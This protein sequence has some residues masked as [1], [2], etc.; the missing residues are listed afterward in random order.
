[1]SKSEELERIKRVLMTLAMR[2]FERAPSDRSIF[3]KH[4]IDRLRRAYRNTFRAKPKAT[5]AA[6]EFADK[7]QEWVEALVRKLELSGGV[8]GRA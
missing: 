3:I 8:M 2:A 6:M 4:E 5:A 7:M 1:M